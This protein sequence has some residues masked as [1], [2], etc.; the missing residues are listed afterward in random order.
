VNPVKL[1]L[2][3]AGARGLTYAREATASGRARVVGVAEPDAE[4][5]SRVAAE[6]SVPADCLFTT[7]EEL[8]AAAPAADAVIVAT[9]DVLHAG[10]AIA[11][12]NLGYHLLLEKPMA[13]TEEEC[14]RIVE[15]VERAGVMLVVCHV[16]RYTAYSRALER[17]IASGR[18][19]DI[20]SVEHL[21][22]VGW[23]H[24][25]HSY[26]RGNWRRE[27]TSS[28][29]LMSKSCHDI[30]WL[31]H[32]IGRPAERVSSFGGLFEFR[33]DRKPAGASKR[34]LTCAVEPT[35]PYSA[36]RI[37]LSR[38]GDPDGERWPLSTV[39]D[40]VS[41]AGLLAA[42]ADGPYGRCVYDCDNDVV[43]HQVVNIEYAGG[44]TASFTMTAFTEL[45]FRKTKVFGTAGSIECDG[46]SLRV[47]DFLDGSV[48]TI[49]IDATANA[50]AADGHGGGDRGLVAAFL[51]AVQ[52]GDAG[53]A[54]TGPRESLHS[55][56]VV[57]AAEQ[58]RKTGTVVS[59]P[60]AS[61]HLHVAAPAAP[62]H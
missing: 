46:R 17:V 38:V 62:H 34:C 13:P 39:S 35:C 54:P 10:P 60:S 41:E 56:Q 49:N 61:G 47:C 50:S 22:P 4:R 26:V 3:G 36:K 9:Q 57:W 30:D 1:L 43:D 28:S 20:V 59:L 37:Y 25:A 15:A 29:M 7:W 33:A 45:D 51:D 11:F 8:A 16:L 21:E 40:D 53:R 55:H 31:G 52:S 24:Q 32:I 27:D 58:A 18:V 44:V 14:W 5:R 23:W 2:V 12:A 19:G 6:C 42:L 48:E